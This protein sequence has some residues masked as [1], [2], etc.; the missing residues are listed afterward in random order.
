MKPQPA[1]YAEFVT[2]SREVLGLP[3]E[4]APSERLNPSLH[5][6]MKEAFAASGRKADSFQS[7]HEPGTAA[8]YDDLEASLIR[9]GIVATDGMLAR[10]AERIG[11]ESGR[12]IAPDRRR[13]EAALR[14]SGRLPQ[15]MTIEEW[16]ER[17]R[18]AVEAANPDLLVPATS[19][20]ETS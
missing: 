2:Q 7:G 19:G 18:P 5:G 17:E 10:E 20:Q 6:L 4:A 15:G 3:P 13:P 1:T 14:A 11:E 12:R 9:R 8:W 16:M